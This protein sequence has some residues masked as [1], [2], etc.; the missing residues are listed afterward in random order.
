MSPFLIAI[1]KRFVVKELKKQLEIALKRRMLPPRIFLS[2]FCL[3]DNNSKK[4]AAYNDSRYIPFYYYLGKNIQP[5][6]FVEIGFGIGLCSGTFFKSCSSVETFIAFQQKD[7]HNIHSYFHH[8]YS[9][10]CF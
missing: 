5:K 7:A 3:I 4:A 10:S 9:I 6:T 8:S 1:R 2:S